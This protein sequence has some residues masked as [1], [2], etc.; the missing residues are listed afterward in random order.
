MELSIINFS[1]F[2]K[3]KYE[4]LFKETNVEL[5]ELNYVGPFLYKWLITLNEANE[6]KNIIT[7]LDY[8]PILTGF[9]KKPI[10]RSRIIYLKNADTT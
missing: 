4:P 2:I 3:L 1:Q 7:W 6:D 8:L 5:F 10:L 9:K